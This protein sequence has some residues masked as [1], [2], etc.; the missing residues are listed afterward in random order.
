MGK[1]SNLAFYP[2]CSLDG[3]GKAYEKSAK[4]VIDDL[5]ISV[6]N[7]K[8]YNCCGATEVKTVSYDLSVFL[9]TRNLALAKDMGA[10]TVVAPCNGCVYSLSRANKAV[11][12]DPS[13][14][15]RMDGYLSKAGVSS[16][17][18]SVEVKHLLEVIYQLAGPQG[19]RSHVKKPLKGLKVA[20]YY[21]C[22]YT[23]PKIYTGAGLKDDKDNPEHP[24]FMDD[25]LEAAGATIVDHSAKTI[26]CGGGH[27]VSDREVSLGF[28]AAIL[29][30]ASRN[31]ADVVSTMCPLGHINIE[32]NIPKIIEMYG[33][34]VVVP[35]MYFTQLLGLAFGHSRREVRLADNF[36]KAD[37]AMR[38]LGF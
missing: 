37:T 30:E 31:G 21:G 16:Y 25:L 27:A 18:G 38:R 32:T 14:R 23:R 13:T 22:L 24:H 20:C 15:E 1:E 28:S 7:I 10:S 34:K 5:G 26:C 11:T 33:D 35:V 8:N 4:A 9:P 17:D 3:L 6:E 36:S 19:V 12:E 2:G 29:N